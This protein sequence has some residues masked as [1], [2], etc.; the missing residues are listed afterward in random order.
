[1]ALIAKLSHYLGEDLSLIKIPAPAAALREFLGC[2]V[3]AVTSR[4]PDDEN[5][6]T[7]LS[8]RQGC[9]RSES[10]MIAFHDKADPSVIHWSCSTCGDEGQITGWEGTIWDKR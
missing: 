9:E 5:Y 2:I 6:G 8:C 10:I 7:E 1:M 4:D 3:E